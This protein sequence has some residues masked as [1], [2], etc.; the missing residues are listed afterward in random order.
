MRGGTE[1]ARRR[2]QPTHP[3]EATSRSPPTPLTKPMKSEDV[4]A[5]LVSQPDADQMRRFAQLT[6]EERFHWL[7]DLIA[8]CHE[9]ATPEAR[10]SW[11][12]H[13]TLTR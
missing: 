13:K 6:A 1:A 2:D 4:T 7:V 11:R 8:V 3:S 5:S 12:K 9:L 10:E